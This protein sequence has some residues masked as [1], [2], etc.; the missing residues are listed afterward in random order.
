[1]EP[2]KLARWRLIGH[3]R[4]RS[5]RRKSEKD[6]LERG[7]KLAAQND[8]DK[9][10]LA[11]IKRRLTLL[12]NESKE[13]TGDPSAQSDFDERLAELES[14]AEAMLKGGPTTGEVDAIVAGLNACSA[15]MR[16]ST[17]RYARGN[18]V[19]Q[20]ATVAIGL[21]FPPFTA[22][23]AHAIHLDYYTAVAAI[24]PVLLVAG[25]VELAALGQ[26]TAGW[27]VLSF[28]IPVVGAAAAALLVL[29]T[30][31]STPAAFY[32]TIWGLGATLLSL[33]LLIVGHASMSRST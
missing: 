6:L 20:L 27:G 28:A 4:R 30:H 10:R 33:T 23:G 18:L 14:D 25:F 17:L 26:A 32:L 21:Q 3:W 24:T 5:E 7:Q 29:A 1:M 12:R 22:R 8:A 13:L 19:V 2:K 11:D 31:N 15:R 16:K 9:T